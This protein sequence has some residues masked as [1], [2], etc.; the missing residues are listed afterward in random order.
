M[1]ALKY[2]PFF[3]ATDIVSSYQKHNWLS[4]CELEYLHIFY[5]DIHMYG[6]YHIIE[7]IEDRMV[8]CIYI[9]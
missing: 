4:K 8:Q 6:A 3:W 7:E 1:S 9:G 5:S 2:G